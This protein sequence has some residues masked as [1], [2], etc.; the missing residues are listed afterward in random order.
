MDH[1]EANVARPHA[2]SLIF[3]PEDEPGPE[4]ADMTISAEE[5][6]DHAL[7]DEPIEP[8]AP[9]SHRAFRIRSRARRARP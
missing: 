4:Y 8:V 9:D 3:F 6:V 2:R 7:A 1:F 5:V